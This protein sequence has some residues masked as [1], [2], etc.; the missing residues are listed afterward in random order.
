MYHF[1]VIQLVTTL[2]SKSSVGSINFNDEYTPL[3]K[4]QVIKMAPKVNL[5]FTRLSDRLFHP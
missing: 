3:F 1:A 4:I 5:S 2:Y